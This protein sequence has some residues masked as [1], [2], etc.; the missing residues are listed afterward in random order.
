MVVSCIVQH[1]HHAFAAPTMAQRCLRKAAQ[2]SALNTWAVMCTNW[3]V[4][5]LTAPKQAVDLRVGAC[6]RT[7]SRTSGGTHIRRDHG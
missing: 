3:P 6:N 1:Y 7:G 4:V 2:V 5:K